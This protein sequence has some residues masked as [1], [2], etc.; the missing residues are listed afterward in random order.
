MVRPIIIFS[1]QLFA[2]FALC[3]DSYSVPPSVFSVSFRPCHRKISGLSRAGS[4][5]DLR[6]FSSKVVLWMR[7]SNVCAKSRDIRAREVL[8]SLANKKTK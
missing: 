3:Y 7:N 5:G 4:F 6:I 2:S 8:A 1:N